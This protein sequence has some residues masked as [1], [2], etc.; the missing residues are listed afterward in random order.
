MVTSTSPAP[1]GAS[2]TPVTRTGRPGPLSTAALTVRFTLGHLR[3]DRGVT[4]AR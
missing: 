1:D 3:A 4:G 2:S